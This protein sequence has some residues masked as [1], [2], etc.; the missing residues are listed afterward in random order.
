[1]DIILVTQSILSFLWNPILTFLIGITILV[2][3]HEF[4][5]YIVARWCKVRVEIFSVGFGKEIFG[6]TDKN[7]TRWK[8]ASI[9]LGGYVKM[10]GEGDAIIRDEDSQ[11][12]REMTEAERKVSFYHK[13]LSH[14]A[15][16]VAAGPA[17]NFIF[18]ILAFAILFF[19][20]GVPT[21]V[22]DKQLSVVG[23]VLPN[24]PAYHSGFSAGDK[25]LAI[26]G[27]GILYFAELKKIVEASAGQ[28]LSVKILRGKKEKILNVI[29]K[30]TDIKID[31]QYKKVGRLGITGD[32]GELV[33]IKQGFSEALLNGCVKTYEFSKRI[34]VFVGNI[35]IG[36][37]STSELGGILR[38]ADISG[39]VADQG[40]ANYI[41]FLA[42]LS[43]NLGL[44]NLFPIPMLDGGH[45]AFYLFEAL[46][47]KPLAEKTQEYGLR[48]GFAL[49]IALF[50][51]VTW[52]DFINLGFI[53]YVSNLF[54]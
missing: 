36:K 21:P 17:I 33:N 47:G 28:K 30:P 43:I 11:S 16:I 1:M 53:N 14:R 46:R 6:W 35:F 50:L 25:I 44:I 18:A 49:V 41:S 5:H 20:V 3:V 24:S 23:S 45:L 51:F 37:E 31:G 22:N 8:I 29:P 34:L 15:Y 39:K 38:I 12:E 19:A 4:G 42:I 9:P 13:R 10:F 54:G 2:F 7:G 48:V 32:P 52:N 26:N 27:N 40:F